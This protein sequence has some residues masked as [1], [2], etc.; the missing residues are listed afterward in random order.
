MATIRIEA[1]PAEGLHEF[2]F[3][4]DDH[5]NQVAMNPTDD[6]AKT[7]EGTD[8]AEGECGD[9]S[10]HRLYYTIVG[11]IG[12]L[13]RTKI[14]CGETLRKEITLEV[15]GPAAVVHANVRFRL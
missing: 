15:F 4:L 12:A 7:F 9:G 5:G 10:L 14:F 1:S 6:E 2:R 3:L 8:D 13:L 11:P